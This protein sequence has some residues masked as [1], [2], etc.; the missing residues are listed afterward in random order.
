MLTNIVSFADG[1]YVIDLPAGVLD[2][3]YVVQVEDTRGLM[4][5]FSF[6]PKSL[7]A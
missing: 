2:K 5:L 7:P 1:T 6:S 3:A 4:V